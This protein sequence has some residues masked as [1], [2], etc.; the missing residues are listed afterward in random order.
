[1]VNKLDEIKKELEV[2][3]SLDE[4]IV[5]LKEIISE[6]DSSEMKEQLERVLES[7]DSEKVIKS[8]GG[9]VESEEVIRSGIES[10]SLEGLEKIT[11]ID[12]S[13]LEA[14]KSDQI[15]AGDYSSVQNKPSED[16]VSINSS[17]SGDEGYSSLGQDERLFENKDSTNLEINDMIKGEQEKRVMYKPKSIGDK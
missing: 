9:V 15:V 1:M 13:D 11:T 8:L 12:K 6:T 17:N 3:D 7:L 5:R 10:T 16:Y 14:D 4:R 2:F